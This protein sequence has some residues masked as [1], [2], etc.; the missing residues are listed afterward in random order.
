MLLS[1]EEKKRGVITSSAGN[2]GQ[3]LAYHANRAGIKAT[4]VM[5][6]F[7]SS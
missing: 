7:F 6:I 4:I 2:H 1:E 5:Y 3:A